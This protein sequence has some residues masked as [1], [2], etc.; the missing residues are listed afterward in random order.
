MKKLACFLLLI[1]MLAFG[2]NRPV[3]QSLMNEPASLFDVAMLRLQ[4]FI[5]WTRPYMLGT[6]RIES[7]SEVRNIDINAIYVPDDSRIKVSA[8]VFDGR[9]TQEQMDAGCGSVLASMKIN[10]LKNLPG[11]FIHVGGSYPANFPDRNFNFAD[12]IELSCFVYGTSTTEVRY[13]TRIPL[14]LGKTTE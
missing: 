3:I 10:L 5:I 11:L 8:S 2:D 4:D 14:A 7:V 12:L 6:Y 13:N 9:S 1:P